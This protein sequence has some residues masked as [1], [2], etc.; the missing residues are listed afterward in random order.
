MISFPVLTENPSPDAIFDGYYV[1]YR[2]DAEDKR[3]VLN[4]DRGSFVE[5][6]PD[7]EAGVGYWAYVLEDENVILLGVPVNQLTLSL[8]QGW[9]LI[10][11]PYGGS[12]IAAPADDPDISVLPYAFTWN[13][14]EKSYSMTQLLEAGKG[15]WA[16]A[17]RD[18]T[19][20]LPD[21]LLHPPQ[22]GYPA[23]GAT[24]AKHGDNEIRINVVAGS[25]PAGEW[26]YSVSSTEG[27][28]SWITG[29]S[30]LAA[31][32]VSLG[33][34][35]SGTYYVSLRHND[36]GHIYFYDQTITIS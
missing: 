2:W 14:R 23:I 19:L 17:L 25:L 24:S 27:S 28:Y 29:T 12:G 35:A 3:Y 8:R 9:S 10:G 34:Y 18:C 7:V 26:A 30:E 21:S 33:T 13:A 5:P 4:A 36:S 22:P 32:Y 15:Y 31:P 11:P 20:E 1:L 6:D 16:Y